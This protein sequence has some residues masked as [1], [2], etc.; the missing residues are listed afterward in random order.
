[1]SKVIKAITLHQPWASAVALGFK[2]WETRSWSAKH[3]GLIAI[4]AAKAK[5]KYAKDFMQ[6]NLDIVFDMIDDSRRVWID[7]FPAGK[8]VA[9]AN[10]LYV[11]KGSAA[12]RGEVEDILGDFGPGRKAWLL[13]PV[14]QLVAPVPATGKMSIWDW[15]VPE[16]LERL[17][18]GMEQEWEHNHRRGLEVGED[19]KGLAE[20]A[21]GF[22][23]VHRHYVGDDG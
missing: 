4:H 13:D 10:L 22:G 3:R 17:V 5:P 1:M 8:V 20:V 23:L 18:W 6:E 21:S 9:I 11:V 14:V 19:W 12:K 15:E 16:D 2:H 7:P